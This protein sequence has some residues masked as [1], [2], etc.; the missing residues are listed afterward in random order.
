MHYAM[1]TKI[2]LTPGVK[3]P[4]QNRMLL[5]DERT[6]PQVETQLDYSTTGPFSPLSTYMYMPLTCVVSKGKNIPVH[7]LVLY[8]AV[9]FTYS[10][11]RDIASRYSY[12]KLLDISSP[13]GILWENK[14]H[15]T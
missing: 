3:H 15:A 10:P 4:A 1:Q 13:D 11:T 5:H 14:K 9:L 12:K 6:H 2:E 7:P 8:W